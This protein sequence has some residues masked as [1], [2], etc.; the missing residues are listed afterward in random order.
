MN[1]G[2][3]EKLTGVEWAAIRMHQGAH[4]LIIPLKKGGNWVYI[5]KQG[6]D[7]FTIR[8][9]KPLGTR[10]TEPVKIN[11]RMASKIVS[12]A[13]RK[14]DKEGARTDGSFDAIN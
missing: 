7:E 12:E 9:V 11:K 3:V 8:I 5:E 10:R 13:S 2:D 6:P 1:P 14:D 4:P